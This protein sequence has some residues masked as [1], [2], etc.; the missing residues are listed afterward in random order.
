MNDNVFDS[1]WTLR[2]VPGATGLWRLHLRPGLA[3]P[4]DATHWHRIHRGPH[5]CIYRLD[6]AYPCIAKLIIPRSQPRDSMRKY[7]FCQAWRETRGS[8]ILASL[9]L[10]TVAIQ[11]WGMTVSPLARYE[12]VLFMQPLP[13][14]ISGLAFIRT[15]RDT[16]RRLLVLGRLAEQ[17]A[18][19]LEHGF[20]HKDAH[21][22]NLYIT[23]D[24]ALIWIDNDLRQPRTQAKRRAGLG[25]MLALLK[26]TARN[27]L[28]PDEW[29]FLSHRLRSHLSHTPQGN[30]LV[31]EIS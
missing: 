6:G 4:Q 21:F 3:I 11:G 5:S 22:D 10:D 29:Q 9:R 24:N 16:H 19:M 18:R 30:S 13:E 26:T 15:E 12:S 17:L 2:T 20:I 8:A 14:A 7:G 1:S 23:A 27:D 28:Q 31:D 25:K